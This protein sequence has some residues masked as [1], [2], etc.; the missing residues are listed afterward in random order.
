MEKQLVFVVDDEENLRNLISY[1]LELGNFQVETFKNGNE[2]FDA[3]ERKVP[4][5]ITLDIMLEGVDGI[6]ITKILQENPKT[7]NIPIIL[8]SA[9]TTDLDLAIGLNSGAWDYLKKPFSI[10]ELI[11]RVKTNIRKNEASKITVNQGDSLDHR[12]ISTEEKINF[13]SLEIDLKL[14]KVFKKKNEI[15]LTFKE[16]QLLEEFLKC[17]GR[18]LTREYL[19][20]KIWG[21]SYLGESRTVD[22]HISSLRKKIS[23]KEQKYITTVRGIGYRLNEEED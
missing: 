22:V 21:E 10:T 23:T 19:L 2:L 18:I 8:I 12:S 9:R 6:T 15:Q 1:N 16:F 5:L 20:E 7:Q 13:K 17:G 11:A 14:R 4:K 3:L